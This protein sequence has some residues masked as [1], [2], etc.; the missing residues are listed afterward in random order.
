MIL[1]LF[2]DTVYWQ[3][4]E[5]V[6][7]KN[8]YYM[9][10]LILQNSKPPEFWCFVKMFSRKRYFTHLEMVTLNVGKWKKMNANE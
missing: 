1:K 4:R 8:K 10:N 6:S 5:D 2:P 9:E 7:I 3:C